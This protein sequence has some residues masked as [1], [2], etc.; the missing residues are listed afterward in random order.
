MGKWGATPEPKQHFLTF[1]R[2]NIRIRGIQKQF[3]WPIGYRGMSATPEHNQYFLALCSSN[4]RIMGIQKPLCWH[5]GFGIMSVWGATSE[6]GQ[7][8]LAL[9]SSK[10]PMPGIQKQPLLAYRPLC[11][12]GPPPQNPNNIFW[13]CAVQTSA[14]EVSKTMFAGV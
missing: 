8:F 6:P 4:N 1:C 7:H 12:F 14:S 11:V 3:D 10:T 5:I 13:H 2:S 9:C